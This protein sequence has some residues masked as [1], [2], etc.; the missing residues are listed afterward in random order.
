MQSVE[1]L[2]HQEHNPNVLLLYRPFP[3]I[4]T[5]FAVGIDHITQSMTAEALRFKG[6]SPSKE[7]HLAPTPVDEFHVLGMVVR[8]P[9]QKAQD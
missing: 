2:Q 5:A 8:L 7:F 1:G 4:Y 9:F 3:G 6:F